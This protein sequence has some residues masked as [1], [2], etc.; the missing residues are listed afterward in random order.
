MY[1]KKL[2]SKFFFIF[3]IIFTNLKLGESRKHSTKFNLQVILK[4]LF[5]TFTVFSLIYMIFLLNENYGTIRKLLRDNKNTH[6]TDSISFIPSNANVVAKYNVKGNN[7][8]GMWNVYLLSI[9]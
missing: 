3:F 5:T 1:A 2:V 7:D 6:I 9:V 8:R 4:R